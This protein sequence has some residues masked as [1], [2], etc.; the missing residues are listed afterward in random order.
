[1]NSIR[2]IRFNESIS[3]FINDNIEKATKIL[4]LNKYIIN[5][6]CI[7]IIHSRDIAIPQLIYSCAQILVNYLNYMKDDLSGGK[8]LIIFNGINFTQNKTLN[9]G[10]NTREKDFN[11]HIEL[12][13]KYLFT[14]YNGC[15]I[16]YN[17]TNEFDENENPV[18]AYFEKHHIKFKSLSLPI[19]LPEQTLGDLIGKY[20]PKKNKPSNTNRKTV[21]SSNK[22]LRN[23][24]SRSF[25]N[26]RR[27]SKATPHN[28][29]P[30]IH[31]N[32]NGSFRKTVGKSTFYV[33]LPNNENNN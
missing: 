16:K 15:I 14:G 7:F 29:I 20:N 33:K 4:V 13:I 32:L 1:M 10:N 17:P 31:S 11:Y 24:S 21:K 9:H 25:R 3:S 6:L 19:S 28:I 30:L 27:T 18:L 8:T 2:D 12:L 26:T 22:T 23:T 5:I